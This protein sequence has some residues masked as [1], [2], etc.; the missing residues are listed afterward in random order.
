MSQKDTRIAMLLRGNGLSVTRQRLTVFELLE[1]NEPL[2]MHELQ[3]LAGD[4]LDRASLYRTVAIFEK[5][6]I[7]R[8][9]NIG[10][11]Y[12]IELSDTFSEHHHHLTCLGCH[13]VIPINERELEVFINSLSARYEFEP[14]EH[15]IELQGYCATCRNS[16]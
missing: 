13:K 15:Q 8:R 7:A 4:R 16:R 3:E 12:K 11:K 10:W 2:T 1:G 6:G 5:L 9:V 14:V